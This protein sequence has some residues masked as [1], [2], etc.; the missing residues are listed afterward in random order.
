M[1]YHY[2]QQIDPKPATARPAPM[3]TNARV[4]KVFVGGLAQG[5]T[6]EDL[7]QYFAQYGT[8]S[9]ILID[10]QHTILLLLG[11]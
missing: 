6:P 10:A 8:V 2:L 5:T 3:A 11:Y 4:K 7:K 1:I 9:D